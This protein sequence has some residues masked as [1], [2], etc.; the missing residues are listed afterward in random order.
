[1]IL[2]D[3]LLI[4]DV[5]LNSLFQQTD[6]FQIFF[7]SPIM[8]CYYSQQIMFTDW[9]KLFKTSKAMLCLINVFCLVLR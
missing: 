3:E 8:M 5:L 4:Q 7:F 2:T 6:H 9:Q 1:M